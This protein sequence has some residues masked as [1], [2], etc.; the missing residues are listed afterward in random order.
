M[1]I[2]V[3]RTKTIDIT[4]HHRESEGRLVV[5]AKKSE[6]AKQPSES[7]TLKFRLPNYA[8]Q[9]SIVRNSTVIDAQG[10][11][12]MNLL[13]A[14][15]NMFYTLLTGWDLKDKEG[16]D[17]KMDEIAIN[18][19]EPAIANAAIEL[20]YRQVGQEIVNSTIF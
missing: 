7:L 15:D 17:V 5:L 6:D 8:D 4:V 13:T 9:R 3:D 10:L 12:M 11:P 2:L 20:L 14:R 1:G 19:L 16:K 18:N